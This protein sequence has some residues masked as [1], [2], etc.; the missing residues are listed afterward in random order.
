MQHS[1][2]RSFDEKSHEL[3]AF[4]RCAKGQPNSDDNEK[5]IPKENEIVLYQ[6]TIA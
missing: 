6:I 3:G 5:T 4:Q 1:R 2:G